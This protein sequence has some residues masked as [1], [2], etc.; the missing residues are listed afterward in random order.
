MSWAALVSKQNLDDEWLQNQPCFSGADLGGG[1]AGGPGRPL[2]AHF[3]AQ[4]FAA[5]ATPLRNVGKISA[6]PPPPYTNPGSAPAFIHSIHT[7][8]VSFQS[9]VTESGDVAYAFLNFEGVNACSAHARS[10]GGETGT[11]EVVLSL[12]EG[13]TVDVRVGNLQSQR[14][15]ADY[16]SLTGFLI[17]PN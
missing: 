12:Q 8:L 3:E 6:G 11:C 9:I 7:I 15:N 4:F 17:S 5:A 1:G 10:T 14:F 2:T 16:T 13:D